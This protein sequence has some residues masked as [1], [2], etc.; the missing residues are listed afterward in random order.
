MRT[1]LSGGVTGQHSAWPS[2]GST[3]D[4]GIGSIRESDMRWTGRILVVSLGLVAAASVWTRRAMR[5]GATPDEITSAGTCGDWLAG[6]P[7]LDVGTCN[8]LP[9][10]GDLTPVGP[11]VVGAVRMVDAA[12]RDEII[13]NIT[14]G[15]RLSAL[16]DPAVAFEL[17]AESRATKEYE[18]EVYRVDVDTT[19]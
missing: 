5:W 6:V 17:H 12:R 19:S 4:R 8:L 10:A 7:G 15:E 16:T 9:V 11:P 14:A 3:L 18:Q 13:A 2:P 1:I